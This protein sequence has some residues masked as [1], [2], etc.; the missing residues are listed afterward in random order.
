MRLNIRAQDLC[1]GEWKILLLTVIA[2]FVAIAG[3]SVT[4]V[5]AQSNMTGGNMTEGNY[6]DMGGNMSG[7]SESEA[8]NISGLLGGAAELRVNPGIYFVSKTS[9][10]DFFSQPFHKAANLGI[11]RISII[12]YVLIA[13]LSVD[14]VINQLSGLLGI[15]LYTEVEVVFSLLLVS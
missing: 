4:A 7:V 8:G 1:Y 6:T 13:V 9:T 5:S 15:S 11:K 3:V 14:T 12:I 2:T 10:I